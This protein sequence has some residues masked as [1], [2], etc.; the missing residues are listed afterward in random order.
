MSPMTSALISYWHRL[1]AESP[2][3]RRFNLAALRDDVQ[4]GLRPPDALVTVILGDIDDEIVLAAT[5]AYVEGCVS[6]PTGNRAAAV[7]A[8]LEWVRRGL[9]LNPGAVFSALLATGNAVV[10]ERLA[11]LRLSLSA[12]EVAV[13]CRQLPPSPAKSIVAF[14]HEWAELVEGSDDPTLSR[15]S[16][17]LAG[18]LDRCSQAKAQLVAA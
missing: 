5:R 2:A 16:E 11:A 1:P 12:G 17:W 9:A 7:D 3:V 6:S 10:L 14:L 15:H 18:A 4:A 8:A 13:V